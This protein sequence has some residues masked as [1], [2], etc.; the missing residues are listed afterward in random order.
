MV[1]RVVEN[2]FRDF[3]LMLA[4]VLMASQWRI[5]VDDFSQLERGGPVWTLAFG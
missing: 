4:G 5:T 2:S 3:Y 1:V